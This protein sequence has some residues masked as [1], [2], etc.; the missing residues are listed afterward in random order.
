MQA[1]GG[2]SGKVVSKWVLTEGL[3]YKFL[4]SKP[5]Q[6]QISLFMYIL[7]TWTEA[8]LIIHGRG[9]RCQW[10]KLGGTWEPRLHQ[11][12]CLELKED[13]EFVKS[14]IPSHSRTFHRP[15]THY[16]PPTRFVEN[17]THWHKA[18]DS[19]AHKR[20]TTASCPGPACQRAPTTRTLMQ[21]DEAWMRYWQYEMWIKW[22]A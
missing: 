11:H 9:K 21:E 12:I 13:H 1:L 16:G 4:H 20:T 17:T 7:N 10:R 5:S 19:N 22:R 2:A 8:I 14:R 15:V 6:A 18:H 3:T